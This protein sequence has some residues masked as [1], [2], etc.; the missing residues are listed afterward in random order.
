MRFRKFIKLLLP[1]V[2]ILAAAGG[3][4]SWMLKHRPKAETQEPEENVTHAEFVHVRK[5]SFPVTLRTSGEVLPRTQSTLA[6]Q[7][8][9]EILKVSP[10]FRNGGFFAEGEILL[11]LDERDYIA[12][13]TETAAAL[14]QAETALQ[15]EEARTAQALESWRALGKGGTVSDL[16]LRKPQSKEAKA[17]ALAA[18]ARHERAKR[19]LER[20]KIIAPY[21]GYVRTKAVDLGQFVSMGT[22]LGEI[23]A[24][25]YVEV[26]L[27]L[28][29][30]DLEF[31]DLPE[32][33]R[34]GQTQHTRQPKVILRDPNVPD[35]HWEG[36]IVRAEGEFD[37][38]SRKLFVIAQVDDPYARSEDG[39]PPLKIGQF[40]NAEIEGNRLDDVFVIPEQAVRFGSEIKVIDEENRIRFREAQII[41]VELPNVI[42]RDGLADGDRLCLTA[43][44]F[45]IEGALVD[46]VEAPAE[47]PAAETLPKPEASAQSS[48][49]GTSS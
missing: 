12:A 6:P 45:A 29:P 16:T 18:A 14:A 40:V 32:A 42:V 49:T 21:A 20:T 22:A 9:G 23:F 31:I 36:K 10:N 33:Y 24:I 39:R 8:A 34:E 1:A 7:V 3:I 13:E 25:D 5:Q 26:R 43:L 38:R 17:A 47:P 4:G 37:A 46:P 28:D 2:L 35:I 11:E 48:D 27:P 15:M 44:P 19:D 30:G 41:W